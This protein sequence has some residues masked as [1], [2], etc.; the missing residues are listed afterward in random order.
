ME[1]I[2]GSI[3][4]VRRARYTVLGTPNSETKHLWFVLHGYGQL[5]RYFI[6]NFKTVAAQ[7]D[8]VVV[9]PEALSRFYLGE[10]KWK[11]VGAS[12]MTKEDRLNEIDDQ[13]EYLDR[14]LEHF[15][16]SVDTS[17]VKITLLGFS[18]GTSTAWRWMAKGK[19]RPDNFIIW[20]GTIPQEEIKKMSSL[21]REAQLFITV[22][23]QD[24][25]ISP[26]MAK[27]K[28]E[29]AKSFNPDAKT[30]LFDDTHRIHEPTLEKILAEIIG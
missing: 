20:A 24:K 13:V 14:L 10:E 11:R 18:Q 12:W 16:N 21:L 25:Y 17:K 3:E 4:T 27:E 1:I 9:A 26:E 8:T 2:E 22:G 6:R 5:S 19:I 23:T 30:Y 7:E 15:Q 29:E 28:L